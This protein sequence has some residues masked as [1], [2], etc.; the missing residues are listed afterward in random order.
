MKAGCLETQE[1]EGVSFLGLFFTM[2]GHE[3]IE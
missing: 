2:K 1:L 3:A